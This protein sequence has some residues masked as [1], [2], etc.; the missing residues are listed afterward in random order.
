MT[1]AGRDRTDTDAIPGSSRPRQGSPFYRIFSRS[2]PFLQ[3]SEDSIRDACS[4]R[5]LLLESP[6]RGLRPR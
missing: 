1:G 2:S 6:A 5:L 3:Q 4:S